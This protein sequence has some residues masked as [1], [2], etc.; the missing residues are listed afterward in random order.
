MTQHVE[1]N[2][3]HAIRRGGGIQRYV[4]SKTASGS[5]QVLTDETLVYNIPEGKQFILKQAF[6]GVESTNDN[7]TFKMIGCTEVDGGGTPI[8]ASAHVKISTGAAPVGDA[9]KVYNFIPG[10]CIK[11]SDG[12]RSITVMINANDASAIISCGFN[13]WVEKEV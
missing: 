6:A 9:T 8:E 13:G 10:V 5:E 4:N 1:S 7:C 3:I 2:G 12:I 11:Y